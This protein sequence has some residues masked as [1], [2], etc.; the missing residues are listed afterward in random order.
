MGPG[1]MCGEPSY[2]FQEEEAAW[3]QCGRNTHTDTHR[4][5]H[6]ELGC[7]STDRLLQQSLSLGCTWEWAGTKTTGVF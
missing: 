3:D 7:L 6:T 5:T 1:H 2:M 4:D